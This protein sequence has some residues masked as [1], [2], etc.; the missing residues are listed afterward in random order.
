MTEASLSRP[1][2][3]ARASV[4][5]IA[6]QYDPLINSTAPD[7]ISRFR[8]GLRALATAP[9][10]RI[11]SRHTHTQAPCATCR[12]IAFSTTWSSRCLRGDFDRPKDARPARQA[13]TEHPSPRKSSRRLTLP[14]AA[15]WLRRRPARSQCQRRGAGPSLRRH[16]DQ[17]RR[18]SQGERSNCSGEHRAFPDRIRPTFVAI[19]EE[20]VVGPYF[21]ASCWRG[22]RSPT[23]HRG[24][25]GLGQDPVER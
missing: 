21:A 10:R 13:S 14:R 23:L 6:Q 15:R 22:P 19:V 1:A 24:Q 17:A 18:Q 9:P 8:I 25:L 5:G 16:T 20:D 4:T 2:S 11:L 7:S 12:S 3:F